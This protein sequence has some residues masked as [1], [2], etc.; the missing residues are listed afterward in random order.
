MAAEENSFSHSLQYMQIN[1][2]Y[3]LLINIV[4]D[5]PKRILK[6]MNKSSS[7]F[8]CLFI[9]LS[10]SCSFIVSGFGSFWKDLVTKILQLQSR[11]LSK[12]TRTWP[13]LLQ[14]QNWKRAKR[15]FSAILI[16]NEIW[17]WTPL[18]R[19]LKNSWLFSD[20]IS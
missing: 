16:Y 3:L 12:N 20:G 1:V 17:K 7:F 4:V 6:I 14:D 2:V 18:L 11:S 19:N 8:C 13:N 5:I 10:F 9:Y 15:T